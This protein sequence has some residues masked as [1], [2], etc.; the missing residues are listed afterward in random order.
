MRTVLI[1]DDR[2]SV[3]EGLR[4]VMSAVPGV[5]RID[6]VTTADE[7]LSRYA[8]QSADVVFVGT[9]RAVASGAEAARRLIAAHPRAT[10][11]VLG[12]PD[13][14]RSI[15]S[16]VSGGARG[17]LRWDSARPEL[18]AALAHSMTSVAPEGRRS[19][20]GPGAATDLTE[21]EMQV[22]RGMSQGKSNGQVGRELFLSE[23]TVKTHARR[24][25]RKLS[26]ADRAQAVAQGFRRGLVS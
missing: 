8:R 15:A 11:M 5:Q 16:A 9:Q 10:V 19:A 17:Y 14:A 12:A 6:C 18:V 23:D 13:D 1:C 25:F 21:R 22:L 7:L 20:S 26:A 24:L 2:R 3:R 4:R